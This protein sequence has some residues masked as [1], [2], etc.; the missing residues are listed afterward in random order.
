MNNRRLKALKGIEKTVIAT[1]IHQTIKS[2]N[3]PVNNAGTINNTPL[4]KELKLK[5]G[6]KVILTYNVDTSDG[7]TNGARGELMAMEEDNHGN[8]KRLIIKFEKEGIGKEKRASNPRLANIYP[9]RA[10]IDKISFSFS[11]SKSKK[12]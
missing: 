12:I 5:I 9:G 2:F 10:P 8:L 11:I 3:P 6:A 4:Q 7:L 1:C